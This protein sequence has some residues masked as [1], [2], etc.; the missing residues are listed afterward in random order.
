MSVTGA[1]MYTAG[2]LAGLGIV[3]VPRYRV[4]HE[5]TR[6]ELEVLLPE[7]APPPLP[8]Y[9]LYPQSRQLSP[10]V[11]VFVDFLKEAFAGFG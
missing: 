3:Q 1:D 4:E 6:G 8:V 7:L 9:V 5:L 10:R 2:A 11:R